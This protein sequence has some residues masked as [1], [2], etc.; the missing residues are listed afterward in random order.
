M[1]RD[2]SRSRKERPRKEQVRNRKAGVQGAR[3]SHAAC[4]NARQRD[5]EAT[6]REGTH[7]ALDHATVTT[8]H[9]WG[10]VA[11]SPRRRL[12]AGP[13]AHTALRCSAQMRA[14]QDCH[15]AHLSSD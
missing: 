5:R 7:G 8:L 6:E 9:R 2:S 1:G 13:A 15:D 12:A 4:K 3:V 14:E 11:P 10:V